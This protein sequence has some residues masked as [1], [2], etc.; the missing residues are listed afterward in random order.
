M[1]YSVPFQVPACDSTKANTPNVRSGP[2][3]HRDS[4]KANTPNVRSG[5]I[6]HRDSPKVTWRLYFSMI[7]SMHSQVPTDISAK[8]NTPNVRSGAIS[9]KDSPKVTWRLTR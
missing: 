7:Y 2:V 5:P 3:S 9:H 8:A 4:T 6:S 1:I